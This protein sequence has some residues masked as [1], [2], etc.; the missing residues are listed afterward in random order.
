MELIYF[1][2]R[3]VNIAVVMRKPQTALIHV[4][5]YKYLCNFCAQLLHIK[6]PRLLLLGWCF[7][8]LSQKL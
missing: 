2:V 7:L 8:L 6:N 1:L 4:I 5:L 3:L